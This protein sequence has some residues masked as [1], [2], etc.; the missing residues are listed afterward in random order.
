[1][2]AYY[3]DMDHGAYM[4]VKCVKSIHEQCERVISG[5]LQI[6]DSIYQLTPEATDDRP[7]NLLKVSIIGK[8][9]RLL[10]QTHI[11]DEN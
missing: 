6:G 3:Q 10:D 7:E 9:Y 1:A 8:R 4:T 11:Q 5:I 2:V